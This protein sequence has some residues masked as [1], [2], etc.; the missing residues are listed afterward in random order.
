MQQQFGEV[1]PNIKLEI[2]PWDEAKILARGDNRVGA[3]WLNWGR[4]DPGAVDKRSNPTPIFSAENSPSQIKYS[5]DE[6]V[7]EHCAHRDYQSNKW[8]SNNDVTK[9]H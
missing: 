6:R 9:Q 4:S 5:R 1:A 8:L 2:S 7:V 3:S